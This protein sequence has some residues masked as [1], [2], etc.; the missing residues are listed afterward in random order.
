MKRLIEIKRDAF[1][2]TKRIK[3]IDKKFKVYYE[4][5]SGDYLLYRK[6]GLKSVL[7]LNLGQSLDAL[8]IAFILKSRRENFDLILAEMDR[9]NEQ[10]KTSAIS[11]SFER[12]RAMLKELISYA[13]K[14]SSDID[15]SK[16]NIL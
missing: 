12:G 4:I 6:C 5:S 2:I 3:Q 9:Q 16:E 14:K 10:L 11:S 7:E 15:F 1:D 8:T 13:D